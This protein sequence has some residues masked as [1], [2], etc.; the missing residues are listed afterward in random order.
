MKTNSQ[1]IRGS[2]RNAARRGEGAPPQRALARFQPF[3]A[4]VRHPILV[5][6]PPPHDASTAVST[7]R[8]TTRITIAVTM[9][10]RLLI[11]S[12]P[13]D[14]RR[15]AARVVTD[16]HPPVEVIGDPRVRRRAI[17]VR[18]ALLGHLRVAVPAAHGI[19]KW[20]VR[21]AQER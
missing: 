8:P 5:G 13:S 10:V 6:A 4:P 19:G 7:K 15:A 11:G 14:G 16:L 9:A 21:A 20:V 18:T 3:D 17:E 2:V 12:S 1:T